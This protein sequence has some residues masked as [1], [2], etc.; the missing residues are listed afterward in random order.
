MMTEVSDD[1]HVLSLHIAPNFFTEG[2]DHAYTITIVVSTLTVSLLIKDVTIG[3]VGAEKGCAATLLILGV[4]FIF[5][6]KYF[7]VLPQ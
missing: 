1:M 3:V 4:V 5:S 7:K 2:P 6:N